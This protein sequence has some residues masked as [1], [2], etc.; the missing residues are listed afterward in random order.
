[1]QAAIVKR[2]GL[3][4]RVDE[5]GATDAADGGVVGRRRLCLEELIRWAPSLHRRG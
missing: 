3:R 2:I 5:E 4:D 1:M